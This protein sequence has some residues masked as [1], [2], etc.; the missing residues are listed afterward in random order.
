MNE[1]TIAERPKATEFFQS[2]QIWKMAESNLQIGLVG[3]TLVHYK[4]YK[5]E[6]K[7]VPVSLTGKDALAKYLKTNKAKLVQQ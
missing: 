5:G 6:L 7:R 2:G 3:K 4:H 1:T